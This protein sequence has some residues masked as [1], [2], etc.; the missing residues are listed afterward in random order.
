MGVANAIALVGEFS[1][2]S[3]HAMMNELAP[4][5]S[6]PGLATTAAAG[7][8]S[9][10]GTVDGGVVKEEFDGIIGLQALEIEDPGEVGVAPVGDLSLSMVTIKPEFL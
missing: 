2:T 10:A 7:T 8:G 6:L 4:M 1:V 9:S 3:S 5:A